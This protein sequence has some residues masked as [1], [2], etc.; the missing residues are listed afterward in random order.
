MFYLKNPKVMK[1]I[2]LKSF[3]IFSKTNGSFGISLSRLSFV[4]LVVFFMLQSDSSAQINYQCDMEGACESSWDNNGFQENATGGCAGSAIKD[5]VY[6]SGTSSVVATWNDAATI[7]GHTGGQID[8]TCEVAL[9]EWLSATSCPTSEWGVLEIYYQDGVA[10]SEASPGNLIHTVPA[11]STGCNAVSFA[12][13]AGAVIADL[14]LC[15]KYTIG[16]GDNDFVLDELS[17][18]ETVSCPGPSALT[19]SSVTSSTATISWTGTSPAPGI[20]YDYY[21]SSS[22]VAP[23]AGTI[24]T[25]SGPGISAALTGLTASTTY[26]FWARSDCDG[27]DKSS[28]SSIASFGTSC[29]AIVAPLL[30]SFDVQYA[31]PACWQKSKTT[32]SD[33]IISFA[34]GSFTW[35]NSGCASDPADHTGNGGYFAK[36]DLSNNGGDDVGV[37][38][39][40][41]DV[42]ISGLSEPLL[43]FQ[44]WMCGSSYSPL[45]STYVEAYDGASWVQMAKIQTGSASWVTY[46]Y[47]ITTTYGA[48][49]AR[50]R[51]RV[52]DE[53]STSQWYGDI[54]VDDV[55]IKEKPCEA[56]NN[57]TSSALTSTTATIS[58]SQASL[59]PAD[60]YEYYLSTSATAPSASPGTE[61]NVAS[62]V[63]TAA[64]SGLS[65]GTQYYFWVRS[66]CGSGSISDWTGSGTFTTL[67]CS[68]PATASSA[69][70]KD[71][72]TS[73][74][75]EISWT[76]G[77]GVAN[78]VV[79]S[80]SP[81]SGNPIEN[82]TYSTNIN[83]GSGD[84]L[85][86]GYAV[87]SG[88]SN[89]IT[90][91]SLTAGTTYY[92]GIYDMSAS[93]GCYNSTAVALQAAVVTSP[94]DL[95]GLGTGTTTSDGSYVGI[96][97]NYWENNK[98]QILYKQSE[99]GA[100]GN[101]ED[102]SFD[103][104]TVA[105]AGYRTFDNITIKLMH[106]STSSFGTAYENTTGATTVFSNASYAMPDATGWLT[107]DI[108]DWPYN[109]T[110]NLLVEVSWGDNGEYTA[111][112][113]YHNHTDYSSG[114]EYLVTYG[115]WDSPST[116][117]YDGRTDVRPNVQFTKPCGIAAGTTSTTAGGTLT[118]CSDAPT[119][120]ITG[121]DGSATMQWQYSN[122]NTNW[123]NIIGATS[124]SEE[125][126]Y[127]SKATVWIRN[128]LT[129]G[130]VKYS[131]YI[132]HLSSAASGC[133]FWE[134]T[135]DNDPSNTGNW[136]LGSAPASASTNVLV[137][138][139]ISNSPTYGS[140]DAAISSNDLWVQDG[141]TLNAGI[142]SHFISGD[143]TNNGTFNASTGTINM[144]S[145]VAQGINGTN[146]STFYNLDLKNTS[147]G[148]TLGAQTTVGNELSLTSGN[149][150][151]NAANIVLTS[152]ATV[153]GGTDASHVLGTMVK[154]TA[155][156]SKFTFPLGDGTQ[157]KSI[158]ITPQN[159]TSTEW[160]AKYFNTAYSSTTLGSSAGDIDHVSTYEY[161]DL[162]RTGSADGIVEIAWVP[163]NTVGVYADLRLAHF[164]GSAWENI[165]ASPVGSNSSGVLTSTGNVTSF[166]PFTLASSTTE[167]ALPIELVSFSGEKKDNR[168]MLNWT[169]ASEIN[170]AYFTVEKSYNG[171]DFE[172]VGTQE[173]T[174]P[175]T[176]IINYSLSDY[177]VL[178]TLNY[179]RL[180][181]TDF[182]GKFE[183]SNTISIDNRVDNSFKE[184][185][186]RT[187]LLGQEVDEFY[188][189]I[190]IVRYKDGTSQKFYQFK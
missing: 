121:Q 111:S 174:S 168:N 65:A 56:P 37:I 89:S 9:R 182:D 7:T 95:I 160:S 163:N 5:N 156:T 116:S 108:T 76:D 94:T 172:W 98:C 68:G 66:D 23:S 21:V 126:P 128:Q 164:D 152:A 155:G 107:F 114:G 110:D 181:Q 16:S 33:W 146:G 30:E 1:N 170:N 28:W 104:S 167:N 12:I 64:L 106:T 77:N 91:S 46:S 131:D 36:V 118:D 103:I 49:I 14:R 2:L 140:E 40:L 58:W 135:V 179:Y 147:T 50:I 63:Y 183:Y 180:K 127:S 102:I 185:M 125:A 51:L 38:L 62:G 148:V 136:S 123:Y 60:G 11:I 189:G 35:N 139:T 80:E 96:F 138:K 124:S 20:G 53:G 44:H 74:T 171:F 69:F 6:G 154:T 130:C 175:S 22:P 113:Y 166:S 184:I 26:Y 82:T 190:V 176:Q 188:N 54:A 81:L 122:D 10:P 27:T 3:V 186:G 48:S 57:L 132:V 72:V 19:Y 142:L 67:S 45:N 31:L 162:N 71:A 75:A 92:I 129:N 153:S 120:S 93:P 52:E 133:N 8:I 169:T 161:W 24:P 117:G 43:S 70:V 90:I 84:P 134:G 112:R 79:V 47:D 15:F 158:A 150:D 78:L 178:E 32:G 59:L 18:V 157:Y 137:L 159:G 39:Q 55:E 141:A 173:G 151:A 61:V 25:G 4:L 86:G 99:L 17:V 88:T 177:D 109:G 85:L 165:A 119:V 29:A 105:I 83:Y 143:F 115:Y 97:N 145:T 149:L 41:P 187:N 42:D 101:I 73:T 13:P 34:N 100:S 144:K 87:Y